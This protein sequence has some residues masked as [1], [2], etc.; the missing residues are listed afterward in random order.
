MFYCFIVLL[1][2][3]GQYGDAEYRYTKLRIF[4][5]DPA[6]GTF[7][8]ASA[9]METLLARLDVEHRLGLVI[10][11]TSQMRLHADLTQGTKQIYISRYWSFLMDQAFRLSRFRH[12]ARK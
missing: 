2:N 7:S 12:I 5:P 3:L 4:A 9:R 11:D 8:N 1:L 10:G 6:T